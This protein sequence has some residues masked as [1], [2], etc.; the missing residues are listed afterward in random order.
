LP[1]DSEYYQKNVLTNSKQNL[2]KQ[3]IGS[4]PLLDLPVDSR[5]QG[6]N[7]K[8]LKNNNAKR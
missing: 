1:L 8:K 7:F 6:G 4:V 5:L 3:N 2:H